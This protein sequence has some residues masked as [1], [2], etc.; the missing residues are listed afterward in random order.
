MNIWMA[1]LGWQLMNKY[2]YSI[3]LCK[4][5]SLKLPKVKLFKNFKKDWIFFD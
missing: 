4:D 2:Y 5:H 3:H 1:T